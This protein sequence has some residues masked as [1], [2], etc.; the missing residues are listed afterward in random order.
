MNNHNTQYYVHMQ[1]LLSHGNIVFLIPRMS[2][3]RRP[4]Y[5]NPLIGGLGERIVHGGGSFTDESTCN[6]QHTVY[7]WY[8]ACMYIHAF[9]FF[10]VQLVQSYD[11]S[12]NKIIDHILLDF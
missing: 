11:S 10:I 2:V 9:Q 8:I 6:H 3:E 1:D 12:Y 5:I 7:V 4:L